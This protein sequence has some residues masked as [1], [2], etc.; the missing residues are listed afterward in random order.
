MLVLEDGSAFAGIS[1]G[2]EGEFVGEVVFNTSMTGYQEIITDPSYWGQMVVFT[3][4]HIGNVGVNAQDVESRQPYVRAVLARQICEQPSNWR[5]QRPLPNYLRDH[6]VPALSGLDTRR[7]TLILRDRG[8]MRGALSTENLDIE[9]LRSLATEATDMSALSPVGE[10]SRPAPE[11]WEETV[12]AHWIAHAPQEAPPQLSAPPHVAA[13]PLVAVIDCGI[14]HNILR[15]LT[16]LGA[17]VTV[18]PWD[19][20][21]EVIM[22]SRPDGVLISNGPG[23]PR[24]VAT[25]VAHLR[26]LMARVPVYGICLGH[27]LIALASGARIFK[28]PFGHHG[29]NHPVQELATS[30]IEIT[31]QNHNYAV[32]PESLKGLPLEVTRINLYDGTIEGLRHRDLPVACVQ[33]HPEAS[34]GPHD[35]LHLIRDFVHS[36]SVRG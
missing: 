21:P 3:C 9:R 33:Y 24:Q 23:D 11:G 14:K 30:R 28:L 19:T 25:T 16:G 6:G 15:L 1:C 13:P 35:S 18:F 8:V 22:A 36:L 29:G 10:V 26:E 32:E 2:A 20:P 34:P 27:Q 5:S 17:R 4:P 7:L 12:E 31:A